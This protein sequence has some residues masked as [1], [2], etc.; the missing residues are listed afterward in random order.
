M[1]KSSGVWLFLSCPIMAR[2]RAKG[3]ASSRGRSR[4]GGFGPP[5]AGVSSWVLYSVLSTMSLRGS[6]RAGTPSPAPLK[7]WWSATATAW[8]QRRPAASTS[9][10][11]TELTL[12]DHSSK[13]TLPPSPPSDFSSPPFPSIFILSISHLSTFRLKPIPL[14]LLSGFWLNSLRRCLSVAQG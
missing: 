5:S 12:S 9:Q 13:E 8:W 7:L 1:T 10:R 14:F 4:E 2:P 6:C 3:G 11:R